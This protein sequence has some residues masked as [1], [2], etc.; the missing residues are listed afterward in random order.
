[1]HHFIMILWLTPLP[2]FLQT[3][4]ED[5]ENW[6]IVCIQSS[7]TVTNHCKTLFQVRNPQKTTESI[8]SKHVTSL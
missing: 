3:F 1:M 2:I 6:Q 8:F 7:T 5:E 4:R